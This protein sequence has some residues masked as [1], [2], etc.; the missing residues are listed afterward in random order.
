MK[1][2]LLLV[3]FFYF[4]V[5]ADGQINLAFEEYLESYMT[6]ID[7]EVDIT[8]LAVAVKSG[9]DLWNSAIGAYSATQNLE[10]TDLLAMG[11]I[12]KTFVSASILKLVENGNF[13]LS[14][15]ISKFNFNFQNIDSDITVKQLLNHTSGIYNYTMFPNFFDVMLA[16]MTKIYS[17]EEIL[18]TFVLDPAFP[19]GTKQEYSNTNYVLLGMIIEYETGIVFEDVIYEMFFK[20]DN[21]PSLTLPPTN[22]HPN[23]LAHLWLDD[24]GQIVDAQSL[25][26]DMT[27]IFSAAGAAGAFAC[28]VSDLAQWGQDLYTG[29]YLEPALMDS[30]FDYH[31]FGLSGVV[32]YGLGVVHSFTTCNNEFVGHG[33]N[34]IYSAELHYVPEFDLSVALMTN[35]GRGIVNNFQFVNNIICAYEETFS[36]TEET[37]ISSELSIYPNP[38]MD[39]ISFDVSSPGPYNYQIYNGLGQVVQSK[40]TTEN[41]IDVS[42]LKSGNYRI[43]VQMNQELFVSSFVKM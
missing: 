12:S 9:D 6:E 31:P 24:N 2:L 5:N 43:S 20:D 23:D 21:Y 4:L 18:E 11:S 36:H 41:E 42:I 26:I 29:K 22:I 15:P 3:S 7:N 30:L 38:T 25:N 35:D 40:K 34:I 19:K 1:H 28:N 13:V 17:A 33:G 16:D 27:S 10:V 37:A 39:K 8:G 32:D 14:D